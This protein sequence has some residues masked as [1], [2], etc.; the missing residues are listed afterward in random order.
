MK[1]YILIDNNT[2]V[3]HVCTKVNIK[4][5]DYYINDEN[6]L[7]TDYY[8]LN[9]KYVYKGGTSDSLINAKKIIATT[10]PHIK[11]PHVSNSINSTRI[12]LNKTNT[13][14]IIDELDTRS[15]LAENYASAFINDDGTS[16]TDFL[17]GYDKCKELH[18]YTKEDMLLFGNFC[19]NLSKDNKDIQRENFDMNFEDLLNMFENTD[20]TIKIFYE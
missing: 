9:N 16:E 8:L 20:K 5:F 6:I 12:I 1:T 14:N 19:K 3:E 2:G 17:E 15:I 11:I 13:S 10:N 4:G 7:N 18:P